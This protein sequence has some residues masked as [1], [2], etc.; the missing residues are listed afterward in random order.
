MNLNNNI[1]K[2]E[3]CPFILFLI[4]T[5][6]TLYELSVTP[7]CQCRHL[8]DVQLMVMKVN[9]FVIKSLLLYECLSEQS[10]IF[11]RKTTSKLK[12]KSITALYPPYASP[13]LMSATSLSGY[14]SDG[15]FEFEIGSLQ[16]LRKLLE[17]LAQAFLH[18]SEETQE[19]I[20]T[21]PCK[22]IKKKH[23]DT[24]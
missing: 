2:V 10:V 3:L 13:I 8:T 6:S 1:L 4:I 14:V 24:F 5:I 17:L 16:S 7:S 9:T 23:T 12:Q 19:D 11:I 20:I 18:P 15:N 21:H 22:R